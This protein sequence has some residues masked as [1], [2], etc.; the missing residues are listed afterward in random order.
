MEWAHYLWQILKE[1][2]SKA[3]KHPK[4]RLEVDLFVP[5]APFFV[6]NSDKNGAAHCTRFSPTSTSYIF[7]TRNLT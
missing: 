2:L 4:V 6:N 1:K 7:R 5:R 3:V